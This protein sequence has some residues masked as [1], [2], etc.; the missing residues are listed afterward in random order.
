MANQTKMIAAGQDPVQLYRDV[1][2]NPIVRA[3]GGWRCSN[4]DTV[5]DE[6][7]YVA[8]ATAD[9]KAFS[10]KVDSALALL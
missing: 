4:H 3:V 10:D 7:A 8:K 9:I 6:D 1:L 5:I 2:E